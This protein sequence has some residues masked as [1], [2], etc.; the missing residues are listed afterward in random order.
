MNM[1]VT[2]GVALVNLVLGTAYT[3]YGIMTGLEMKRDWRAFGFSHFGTAWLFMAFTCGPHHLAHGVH[4]LNNP[5]HPAGFLDLFSVAVG[6]P[7]GVIWLVLR[8][9]AFAGGQ[10]DRFL[11]GTPS[12]LPPAAVLAS[13]WAVATLLAGAFVATAPPAGHHEAI[14]RNVG[15]I[16]ANVALLVLYLAIG[17]V[18]V[19]T[20][21]T[22]RPTLGGW[23]VSGVCLSFIFP[24]C[25]VMH[26]I[27]AAYGVA[28]RYH[29]QPTG[30]VI[31]VL[32]IPAA[33][34]F[35]FVVMMLH[36]E[37]IHDWNDGPRTVDAAL[38][39]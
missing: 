13:V 33:I 38:V 25:A 18:L 37:A 32:S 11:A 7:V 20:Q 29:Q 8:V 16:A 10:G 1:D 23:S 27:W 12:W 14:S 35:L 6:L 34:Y 19:Q 15:Q 4:L 5:L 30:F 39:S 36:R 22:N 2:L 24:S 9:E 3:G 31:D 26:A 21:L 28:G 17:K